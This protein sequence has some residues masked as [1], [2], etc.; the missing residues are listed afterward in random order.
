MSK[1]IML[2]PCINSILGIMKTLLMTVL[3]NDWSRK[4][5]GPS[6]YLAIEVLLFSALFGDYSH[7]TQVS[8]HLLPIFKMSY[9]LIFKLYPSKSMT[10][11]INLGL[12][13][14]NHISAHFSLLEKCMTMCAA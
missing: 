14:M 9:L 13:S 8:S 4:Q 5:T 10:I 6:F 3:S 11:Q 2:S 12:E 1:R 7:K